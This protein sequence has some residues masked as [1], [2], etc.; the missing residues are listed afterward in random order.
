MAVTLRTRA[1]SNLKAD[2]FY[3]APGKTRLMP[4]AGYTARLQMWDASDPKR[5]LFNTRAVTSPLSATLV[6]LEE[7]HWKLNLNGGITR[8]LPSSTLFELELV[9]DADPDDV[10]TLVTG[11]IN[12]TPQGVTSG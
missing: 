11:K 12:V 1:G 7:S 9:N 4:S 10:I 2:L 6:L 5:V 8:T 3:W